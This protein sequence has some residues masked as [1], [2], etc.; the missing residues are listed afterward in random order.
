M[1]DEKFLTPEQVAEK[2]QVTIQTIYTWMRSGYLPS[3]K[4]G[5]LWR[6]RP[7][8]LENFINQQTRGNLADK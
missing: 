7:S 5:R 3:F 6:V 2:L 8:D 4:M 1:V